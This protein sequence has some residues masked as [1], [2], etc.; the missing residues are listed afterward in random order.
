MYAK[1]HKVHRLI[2]LAI[3]GIAA[4]ASRYDM[5]RPVGAQVG[6]LVACVA[7]LGVPHGALDPVLAHASG[8]ARTP[9]RLARFVLLYVTQATLVVL[10]WWMA[11]GIALAGFL[12]L[13]IWHFRSDWRELPNWQGLAA[14]ATLVCAP[15]LFHPA[16]AGQLFSLL[17]FGV[18]ASWLILALQVTGIVAIIALALALRGLA[19]SKPY[20][21]LE[22]LTLPV[23]AWALPPLL[24]FVVYFCGLHSPRH[25]IETIRQAQLRRSTIVLTGSAFTAITLAAAV[26]AFGLLPVADSAPRLLAIVFV[27]LAALTVP[28]MLLIERTFEK[29][30]ASRGSV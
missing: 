1:A 16:A 18:S 22:L 8:I 28:H 30:S 10:L 15:A 26:A 14:A 29:P 25:I 7:L 11:P 3:A 6:V 24:F 2:Y 5:A 21:A 20:V 4:L 12:L 17:M 23:L 19:Q 9:L 13:S 27:G